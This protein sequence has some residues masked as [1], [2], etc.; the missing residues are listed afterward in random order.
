MR[1]IGWVFSS[2]RV[3]AY[4]A[5]YLLWGG[6]FLAIRDIVAVTPPFFAAGFRF[7]LAGGALYLLT[8]LRGAPRPTGVQ[9]WHSLGLGVVMFGGNYACLF[10]SEQRLAS[11]I[12]AVLTAMVPVWIFLGEWLVFRTQ[13]L[14][15][16][17]LAGIVLGMG[18]VV[19]LSRATAGGS[20][21]GANSIAALVLLLGTLL[22]SI[23]TLWSRRLTLPSDQGMRAALQMLLG[24]AVL[25]ALSAGSGEFRH[26]AAAL[27]AW[28][29]H[30]AF[31]MLYL[32]VAASIVA[33]TAYTWLIHHEPATYVASY[34]YVNP[35]VALAIG[36]SFAHERM[37]PGEWA[38]AAL[39]IAGVLATLLGK[40]RAAVPVGRSL[41]Q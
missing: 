3:L 41:E 20:I 5:I 12:A 11:G 27:H 7:L 18:G 25:F 21:R 29:W 4:A 35:V 34:A 8:R 17:T 40:Q 30:T 19:L 9:W 32:I 31:S 14:T 2:P 38:G 15:G 1:S 23:G 22:F 36:I 26:M 24:G 6:S 39:I 28:R 37:S 16:G 13:R 10:W 33:F